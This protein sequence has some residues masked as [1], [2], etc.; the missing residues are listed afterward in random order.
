[1][2]RALPAWVYNHP[3]L[4]R[5]EQQRNPDAELADRLFTSIRFRRRATTETFDWAPRASWCCATA[6]VPYGRFTTSAAPRPAR[7]LDWCGELPAT[8]HL[9]LSRLDLSHD[10][11]L[12]GMPVRE[13]FPGL[14]RAEH[15]LRAGTPTLPFGFVFVCLAPDLRPV[16]P[17][18]VSRT[19]GKLGEELAPYRC[20][21]HGASRSHHF[22]R[23]E[24]SIGNRDGQLP[25]VVQL[26]IGH[27]G[28]T[29]V[30]SRLRGS[31]HRAGRGAGRELAAR[32]TLRS[33]LVRRTLSIADRGGRP[34]IC[35]R[36]CAAAGGSTAR[37]RISVIRRLPRSDGLLSG[38]AAAPGNP[39]FRR[40]VRLAG[41]RPGTARAR[42][43]SKPH[44]HF[45]QQP[46]TRAV[47]SACNADWHRAAT[48]PA[49]CPRLEGLHA[50]IPQ[51]AA[52]GGYRNFDFGS[53]PAFQP[54][55]I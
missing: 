42:Y 9:P 4:T 16:A 26:P 50:R 13:S 41:N 35:L 48:S 17:P 53:A 20:E 46:K 15:S 3:A 27:P 29:H 55:L 31:G 43:L 12:I 30:H 28:C 5:L 21:P 52:G 6:T 10:G 39:S 45:R 14:D 23:L 47:A 7:L 38:A 37:C 2:P 1:M 32:D 34:A 11:G 19:W 49:R 44:Q 8:H 36:T 51:P 18:P 40:G 54:R 33:T 24:W 22:G 25:R